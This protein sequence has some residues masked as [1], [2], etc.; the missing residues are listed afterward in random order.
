M[1]PLRRS[2]VVIIPCPGPGLWSGVFQNVLPFHRVITYKKFAEVHWHLVSYPRHMKTTRPRPITSFVRS[3][4]YLQLVCVCAY[5]CTVVASSTAVNDPQQA[6][7]LG[8]A[9]TGLSIAGIVVSVV[10]VVVYVAVVR[11]YAADA[12]ASTSSS[13]SSSSSCPSYK[14]YEYGTCYSYRSYVGSSGTCYYGV[15]YG[16]YCY[17]IWSRRREQLQQFSLGYTDQLLITSLC[18][19]IIQIF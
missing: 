19:Y 4:S 9:S 17:S 14:Y 6:R 16:N 1:Q 10:V 18:N 13:Y 5:A 11:S 8:K 3:N 7:R 15:K 2:F 12:A